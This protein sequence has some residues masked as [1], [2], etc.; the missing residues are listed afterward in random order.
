MKGKP[1]EMDAE[2]WRVLDWKAL[3]TIRLNLLQH[4]TYNI[5]M[6]TEELIATLTSM[7]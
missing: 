4:V 1:E 2:K 7:Y 3:A 6:T 5:A